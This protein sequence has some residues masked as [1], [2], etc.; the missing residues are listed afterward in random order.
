MLRVKYVCD[1]PTLIFAS[2]GDDVVSPFGDLSPI[3][4]KRILL[5]L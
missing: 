3:S 4:A 2:I 1:E 5:L